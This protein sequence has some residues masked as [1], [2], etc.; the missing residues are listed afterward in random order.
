MISRFTVELDLGAGP[1]AEQGPYRQLSRRRRYC[2]GLRLLR[3]N[4][5]GDDFAFRW[6]FLARCRMMM[7]ASGVGF[8][9][10]NK[11]AVAGGEM[12]ASDPYH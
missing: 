8:N 11:N 4:R 12:P 2:S 7:P 1:F 3:L 9:W 5:R 10:R 6:A